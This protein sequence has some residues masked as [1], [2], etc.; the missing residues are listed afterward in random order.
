MRRIA[1]DDLTPVQ[2]PGDTAEWRE[3]ESFALSF[4]GYAAFH[5][6]L[7]ELSALAARH[8]SAGTVPETLDELRACLFFHQRSW[9]HVGDVPDEPTLRH[10]R[11]LCRA[12]RGHLAR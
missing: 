10:L 11:A 4:D 12:I 7:D 8:L 6:R 3:L 5:G 1:N 9:R 2:V